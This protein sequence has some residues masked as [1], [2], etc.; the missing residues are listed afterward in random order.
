VALK[1][2]Q[3]H[4]SARNVGMRFQ[5]T[6]ASQYAA[7]NLKHPNRLTK[8]KGFWAVVITRGGDYLQRPLIFLRSAYSLF[9]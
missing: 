4:A 6:Q 1:V 7:L 2:K 9:S 8:A 5:D 3:K